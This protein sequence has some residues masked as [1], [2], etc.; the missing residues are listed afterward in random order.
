MHVKMFVSTVIFTRLGQDVQGALNVGPGGIQ[1]GGIA[2]NL[3]ALLGGAGAN[4]PG[5]QPGAGAAAAAAA[6]MLDAIAGEVDDEAMVELA[7]ALSLQEQQGDQNIPQGLAGLHQGLE[8]LVNLGPNLDGLP[9]LQA[10]AGMLGGAI[11]DIHDE[12]DEEDE[13]HQPQE[14]E[15]NQ[16]E[17]SHYSD[18]TASPP[19]SD[20]ENAQRGDEAQGQNEPG[21]ARVDE[22]DNDE[23]QAAEGS[24]GGSESGGSV[25]ESIAGEHTLSSQ[26]SAYEMETTIGRDAAAREDLIEGPADVTFNVPDEEEDSEKSQ[27]KMHSLR[28]HILKELLGY[29]PKLKD[30]GGVRSI[31]FMQ[32]ILVL[33][34]DLDANEEKDMAVLDKLLQTLLAEITSEDDNIANRASVRNSKREVQLVILRLFSVLMSRSKSWQSGSALAR[35]SSSSHEI[36]SSVVCQKTSTALL[37]SG[38]IDQCLSLLTDLLAYWK[39]SSLED[40]GMKVGSNLLRAR[41]L[42]SP[43]DMSPFF[44][45]QYVKSHAHDVFEAYPQL[46][47][48]MALRLPYQVK[49]VAETS[50]VGES[51][52]GLDWH[53]TLCEYMM[54]QQTPYVRRQVRKLLLYACGSKEKYRELRDLH[55]LGS[56]MSDVRKAI[57]E[58]SSS[59]SSTTKAVIS[60]PYDTLLVIIEHLKACV[61]IASSR[62][63]NWQKFCLKDEGVMAFLFQISFV[64]D[65][66]VSPI[67]LQ[68]LQSAIDAFPASTDATSA[69][70]SRSGKSGSP[71]K[72]EKSKL[73]AKDDGEALSKILAR[74]VYDAVRPEMFSR[75]VEKFLLECN[76]TMVR[77][78]AHGLVVTMHK[79]VNKVDCKLNCQSL[80]FYFCR[81]STPAQKE[82]IVDI[83]W[84]LWHCLPSHGRKA[85][86]FVDL[87]GYFSMKNLKDDQKIADYVEEAVRILKTQN[88]LL[89]NH[90][91]SNV[92]ESLG[93]LVDFNG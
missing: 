65:D 5:G 69:R 24:G 90:P 15:E 78:Q 39:A 12:E 6:N 40:S 1:L 43:P 21:G 71:S 41:P 9:A 38:C 89:A 81:N 27:F 63:Q 76:S 19:G 30:V 74:R 46:L 75:F 88:V 26:T 83:L 60:L 79:Y 53:K 67:V 58:D 55:C 77:W 82:Q 84:K 44:L 56:H 29:V 23:D 4:N 70:S 49:K 34:T 85:A 64:L 54:T 87:L 33:T 48:E 68:L 25:I 22:D 37:K 72:G 11:G 92:Y 57:A 86:Q 80:M 66:G 2:G 28:L 42:M 47:T 91:N 35:Q 3:D 51:V 31:P 17:P 59:L 45:K 36:G 7:I 18:A 62:I 8:H 16:Q 14:E 52:L 50:N 20:D 73:E 93:R 32:V 13:E 10:M 61:D